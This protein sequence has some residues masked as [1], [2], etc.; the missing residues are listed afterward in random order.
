MEL[1]LNALLLLVYVLFAPRG[2]RPAEDFYH[3][4]SFLVMQF[5]KKTYFMT[6]QL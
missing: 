3:D 2:M 4:E 6:V 5:M 1:N